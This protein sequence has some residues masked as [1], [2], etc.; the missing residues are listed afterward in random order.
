[1]RIIRF[2]NNYGRVC[3]GILDGEV[4]R[5]IE[6]DIS[7]TYSPLPNAFRVDE[8]KILPPCAPTKIVCVGLNYIDHAREM[9]MSPPDEPLLF[10]KPPTAVI[11]HEEE[12]AYPNHFSSR[13]DYEGELGVVIGKRARWVNERSWR[14]HVLGFT[15]VNDVTARDIQV[16]DVQFTRAKAFDTFA[17][18]GPVIE[19]ELDPADLEITTRVNGETM[20]RSRT[21]NL[22]FPVPRLLAF[23]TRI[24]TLL[25]GDVI[26]T[27]T[28]AG[29]G[30]M[31]P[32]DTV[33]V[34]IEGIGVLRNTVRETE[35]N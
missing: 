12:I 4:V 7:G 3:T 1:M 35:F 9:K 29:I 25:P 14:E 30:P 5:E 19:T 22:I 31:R 6:G 33:E 11:A 28:P 34:E 2:D 21:S 27:G 8:V 17:P 26:T 16:K 20:Q 10:L 32:G 18:M 15:C 13:V 24:M 23:I